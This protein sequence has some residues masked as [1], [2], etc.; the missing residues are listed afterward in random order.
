MIDK[1]ELSLDLRSMYPKELQQVMAELGEKPFKAKQL[2]EWLHQKRAK[3]YEEMTN[4]SKGLREKLSAEYP[5]E[6]L[7]VLEVQESKLDGTKKFLFRLSDGNVIESVWMKYHHGNSVCISSQVGCRMGCKFCASTIGGLVRCLRA[8]EMLEQIYKITEI[9]GERVSN[10]VVMGTGEPLDNYENL[11]RFVRIISDEKGINLSQRNITVS[12]CGIVPAM[13]KLAEEKLQI[14]LALSLHA[15]NDEKRK[16]LMPIAYQYTMKEVLDAC[17]NY[18]VRT[19]R[20][21]TFEYSLV[22][23]KNDSEEDAKQLS[24]QIRDMNCHVN[25]IPV[26]PIKERD[27]VKSDKK[28]IENFKNKLEKYGINVTI[29]REMGS[30]IDGACGQLRRKYI[31]KTE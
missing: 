30:D 16:E 20:R 7:E 11:L 14:T 17:R 4:L 24:A 3:S 13:Y 12:T 10:V 8:S 2:F 25:L 27:Y 15:P 18:F 5:I 26:N 29:R 19:G 28:V 23:G 9:T 6:N 22:G 21:I 1:R 31:D